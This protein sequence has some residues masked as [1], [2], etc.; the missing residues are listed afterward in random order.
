MTRERAT[1]GVALLA[2]TVIENPWIPIDPT[3]KQALFLSL[4]DDE[5]LYGGSAGGGKTSAALACAAQFLECP[6]Y[7][8]VIFRKT[9][10]QLKQSKGLL[11][12]AGDW[13]GGTAANWNGTELT[14]T[15]PTYGVSSKIKFAGME[16]EQDKFNFDGAEFDAILLDELRHFT[17]SQYTY[18]Y[19]RR[20]SNAGSTIPLRIR[21]FTNPGADWVRKRWGIQKPSPANGMGRAM[22]RSPDGRLFVPAFVDENQFQDQRYI[23]DLDQLDPVERARLKFGD[24]WAKPAGKMF[25]KDRFRIVRRP[26]VPAL[27]DFDA[28]LRIWDVASTE[29]SAENKDPDWLRG[30]LWGLLR[31]E[32]WLLDQVSLRDRPAAVEKTLKDTAREDHRACKSIGVVIE[33]EPGSEAK[34]YVDYLIWRV[35]LEFA[36]PVEGVIG[37]YE[38]LPGAD[39]E[40]RA[41]PFSAAVDQKRVCIV[42]AAWNDDYFDEVCD[43]PTKGRHDDQVDP[44]SA[45]M[46]WLP[47]YAGALR[48]ARSAAAGERPEPERPD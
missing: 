15:F 16:Y 9:V 11:E 18:M 13:W 36:N 46:K 3:P 42:E 45:A 10:P 27:D 2:S 14:W 24:W 1:A 20:R 34:A 7:R 39:K 47:W 12:R 38:D 23:T 19:S 8:A 33:R 29:V 28:L 43:F 17:E 31:G 30:Q 48:A 44:G 32:F 41:R 25:V 4:V 40:T 26:D 22:Q 37:L 5:V 6:G 21:G 35:L